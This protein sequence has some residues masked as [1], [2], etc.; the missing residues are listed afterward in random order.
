LSDLGGMTYTIGS[1]G[2]T[3]SLEDPNKV[4]GS[5]LTLFANGDLNDNSLDDEDRC[6]GAVCIGAEIR[7]QAVSITVT[8]D[9]EVSDDLASFLKP[10][11]GTDTEGDPVTATIALHAGT[12]GEG[13]LRFGP[14]APEDGSPPLPVDP[15][16]VTADRIELRAGSG[17]GSDDTATVDAVTN[18]PR[19]QN[20]NGS[21]NPDEFSI[22]QDAEIFD[23]K[24]DDET[25]EELFGS[26][27]PHKSQFGE[28]TVAD[29]VY[30]LR[31]DAG[32]LRISTPATVEDLTDA[33]L[34]LLAAGE[35]DVADLA[36]ESFPVRSLELGGVGHYTVTSEVLSKFELRDSQTDPIQDYQQKITL[37]SG[38]GAIGEWPFVGDLDFESGVVV[39][40]DEIRLVAGD[41][42]L[43]VAG[44]IFLTVPDDE[45]FEP[46]IFANPDR[47]GAPGRFVFQQ[48]DP[49]VQSQLPSVDQF[50]TDSQG[51]VAI[52]VYGIRSGGFSSRI[53]LTH[54]RYL[55]AMLTDEV[56]ENNDGKLILSSPSIEIERS[57]VGI[58]DKDLVLDAAGRGVRRGG[59]GSR[60]EPDDRRQHQRLRRRRVRPRRA[61]GH[62]SH[63]FQDQTAGRLRGRR[64][65]RR[66]V[67]P[68]GSHQLR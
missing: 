24:T 40:A 42:R 36:D 55:T 29:M 62:L 47:D 49:I 38:A 14:K 48:T 53:E 27:I 41:E 5:D 20:R 65:Y 31:S 44:S 60:R 30:E 54:L 7:P 51:K 33:N 21:G 23:H 10:Q 3:V 58:G 52:D 8:G 63:L 11:G 64:D 35:I 26:T 25:D 66:F 45:S 39:Q 16:I 22:R 1:F 56:G 15:I 32:N 6:V 28:G 50:Q 61:T 59:L 4:L 37:R 43:G 2:S 34:T 67:D 46:P 17:N 12:D 13:D 19:F 18:S 9:L 57:D 68:P